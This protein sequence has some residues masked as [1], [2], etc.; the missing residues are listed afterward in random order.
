MAMAMYVYC[1]YNVCICI[2]LYAPYKI[3]LQYP[4]VVWIW[5]KNRFMMIEMFFRVLLI[6]YGYGLINDS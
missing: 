3:T 5:T 1:K 6:N 4:L 2:M